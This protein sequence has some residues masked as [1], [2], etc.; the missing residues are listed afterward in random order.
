[1]G[2]MLSLVSVMTP[3]LSAVFFMYVYVSCIKLIWVWI[4]WKPRDIR[5]TEAGRLQWQLDDVERT[6]RA[7]Q[8]MIH[9][10]NCVFYEELSAPLGSHCP[11]SGQVQTWSPWGQRDL[12]PAP[13]ALLQARTNTAI[14][15]VLQHGT[16]Y[17]LWVQF[18]GFG[19]SLLSPVQLSLPTGMGSR[20]TSLQRD[21]VGLLGLWEQAK[22]SN[23]SAICN[24]KFK[25]SCAYALGMA[26]THL[27][28]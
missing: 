15:K 14:Y 21:T 23:R 12:S 13:L 28:F 18:T 19:R 25:A 20:W 4:P 3:L 5:Q 10:A 6:P 17:H 9:N 24:I 26:S 8:E 2:Y 11:R 16:V 27:P 1:M 7:W 22:A